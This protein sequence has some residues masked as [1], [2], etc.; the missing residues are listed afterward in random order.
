[1]K[2]VSNF[3]DR[4]YEQTD[5]IYDYGVV[6]D[7]GSSGTRVFVYFWQ[8]QHQSDHN[9][10]LNMKPLLDRNGLPVQLKVEPGLSSFGKFQIAQSQIS[11][12]SS[13]QISKFQVSNFQVSNFK[14][15]NFKNL[16]FQS[17]KFQVSNFKVSNFKN[18]KFQN[19]KFQISKF[20]LEFQKPQI[21]N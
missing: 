5:F 21:S 8:R 15:S 12:I 4:I 11:K 19:F 9:E 20:Q 3:N 7:C 14:V 13:P 18:L 2:Y 10:L 17:F 1:M 6:L 16:K